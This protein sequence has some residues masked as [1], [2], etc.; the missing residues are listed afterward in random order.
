MPKQTLV[1]IAMV[2]CCVSFSEA[3]AGAEFGTP[4]EAQTML[5]RA[6][7]EVHKDKHAAIEQFNHNKPLFRDRDL[8]VFCFD[9]VSGRYTAHEA[10]VTRDVRTLRDAKNKLYGLEMYRS[11]QEGRVIEIT[12]TA[13]VPGSTD[14]MEKRA[15][16]SRVG[17]QV[18]GV[19]AYTSD[20]NVSMK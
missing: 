7:L 1:K 2:A 3:A 8:F 9:G 5:E 4:A 19:S 16:L 13:P 15:Y 10:F 11:A 14:Q 6:V 20:K 17:D 18:C 12:F